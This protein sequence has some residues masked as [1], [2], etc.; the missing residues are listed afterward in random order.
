MPAAVWPVTLPQYVDSEGYQETIG[1]N[2]AVFEPDV[3]TIPMTSEVTTSAPDTIQRK[4]DVSLTELA[5]FKS[6]YKTT[7]K[8]GTLPFT[9]LDPVLAVTCTYYFTGDAPSI[10]H[11]GGLHF[12]V[13]F[14]LVRVAP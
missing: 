1:R 13:S 11:L 12:S 10:I 2:I 9:F 4:M 14:S 3:D 8:S 5:V 7:L 6:F